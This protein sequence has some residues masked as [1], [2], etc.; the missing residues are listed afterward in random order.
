MFIGETSKQ[1]AVLG[2]GLGEDEAADAAG[3]V[4]EAADERE[5]IVPGG[6]DVAA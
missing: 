5:L 2:G 3:G 6:A 4:D 1:D